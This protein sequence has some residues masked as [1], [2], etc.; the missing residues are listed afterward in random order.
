MVNIVMLK[1]PLLKSMNYPLGIIK[2]IYKNDLNEVTKVEV[3]KGKSKEIVKRHV[4]SLIPYLSLNIESTD[5]EIVQGNLNIDDDR[6][7]ISS[8]CTRKRNSAL[9]SEKR[10]K[11]LFENN[12][13]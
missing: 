12:L 11:W 13:A 1:E 6:N 7:E 10:N 8:R 5:S 4:T 3:L 9:I 2:K